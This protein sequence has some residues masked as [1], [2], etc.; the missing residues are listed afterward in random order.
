MK[1]VLLYS[2]VCLLL[3]ANNSCNQ[4]LEYFPLEANASK[5]AVKKKRNGVYKSH[6]ANGKVMSE[7]TYKDGK[8]NG[9]AKDFYLN[10]Q[11]RLSCNYTAGKKDG[12]FMFYH[13][14]GNIYKIAH[15][16]NGKEEGE[17]KTF[18]ENGTLWSESQYTKGQVCLGSKEYKLD[19]DL[20]KQPSIVIEKDEVH[21]GVYSLNISL[22]NSSNRVSYFTGKVPD[23]S[24]MDLADD[25]LIAHST[26]KDGSCLA[27]IALD[28]N[29]TQGKTVDVLA[30]YETLDRNKIL[31]KETIVLD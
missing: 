9:P 16:K 7:V 17:V 2:F 3:I 21:P 29:D 18:Y 22:S 20:R 6:H 25:Q 4:L 26:Q 13:P 12:E 24:C 19:G 23:E 1:K 28:E 30:L 11:L 31:L 27:S 8:R 14:N 5:T 10:G 15:Y